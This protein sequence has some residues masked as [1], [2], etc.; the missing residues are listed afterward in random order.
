MPVWNPS[1]PFHPLP[2]SPSF[3][4]S[5]PSLLSAS[6]PLLSNPFPGVIRLL[7]PVRQSGERSKLPRRVPAEPAVAK[8]I[9]MHFLLKN[10]IFSILVWYLSDKKWRYGFNFKQNEEVPVWHTVPYRPTSSTTRGQ[11]FCAHRFLRLV[12]LFLYFPVRIPCGQGRNHVFK[13][14]GPIPW[15]RLL[16]RTNYG[17]YTQFRGLQY[18]T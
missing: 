16:Y 15:S 2:S 11:I 6:L 7:S 14:G 10:S 3:V 17:W 5:F 8:W 18:V 1:S 13:V 4:L 12:L 9:L